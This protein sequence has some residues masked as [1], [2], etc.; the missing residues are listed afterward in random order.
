MEW[1]TCY[2]KSN[3]FVNPKVTLMWNVTITGKF[4]R[5]WK[6]Q[7]YT[8]ISKTSQSF[9]KFALFTISEQLNE[10]PKLTLGILKLEF[11]Q[12]NNSWIIKLKLNCSKWIKLRH[13]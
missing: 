8:I 13:K 6:Q 4:S 2:T 5:T 7:Q 12:Q 9:L 3:K 11:K 1:N 10:T